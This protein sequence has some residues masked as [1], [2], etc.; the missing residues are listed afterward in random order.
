MTLLGC[1][2][3]WKACVAYE[4]LVCRYEIV[5][6]LC[7]LGLVCAVGGGVL[8]GS[9][10]SVDSFSPAPLNSVFLTQPMHS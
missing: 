10:N 9:L 5:L 8:A 4:T 7:M 6:C 2:I 3:S 1:L